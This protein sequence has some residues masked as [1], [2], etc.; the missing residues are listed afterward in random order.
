MK[1]EDDLLK[2]TSVILNRSAARLRGLIQN[3]ATPSSLE[4]HAHDL[5]LDALDSL[6]SGN[7]L[8]AKEFTSY[9]LTRIERAINKNAQTT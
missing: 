8:K 7:M 3:P 2:E 9:A 6:D 1:N 5:L 4:N